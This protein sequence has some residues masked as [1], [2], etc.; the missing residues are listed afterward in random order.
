MYQLDAKGEE[1][2][3]LRLKMALYGLKQAPRAWY[4][5]VESY[6]SKACFEKCHCDYTLFVKTTNDRNVLI[7]SIY[8]DDLI[9]TGNNAAM[10]HEVKS[11]MKREFDMSDLG[12]MSYFLGVE[13]VQNNERIFINQT[14]YAKEIRFG[15]KEENAVKTPIVPRNR[16]TKEGSGEYVDASF[17]KQ[18]VGS[19]MYLIATR[20][21]LMYSVCLV[22]RYME[23]PTTMHQMATKKIL[24]YL[25]GTVD[26][27]IMYK[28]SCSTILEG[29]ADSDYVGD[30]DDRKS[31]R[32][33]VFLL[34]KFIYATMCA[35]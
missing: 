35:S 11:S 26:L 5:K 3:V 10:F 1:D 22:S 17:Y 27:G 14:K 32:G 9:F 4:N 12:K 7:V 18:M 25:K 2:K 33:Y 34:G 6:F 19:L 8:V 31:T 20:P 16:L 23:K 30:V 13:V 15:M 21:D 28:R 29:Y 24:I